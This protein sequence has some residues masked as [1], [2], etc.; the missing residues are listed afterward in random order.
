MDYALAAAILGLSPV[1]ITVITFLVGFLALKM[2]RDIAVNWGWLRRWHGMAIISNILSGITALAGALLAWTSLTVL[3]FF[4]PVVHRF[5]L[6]AA[7]FTLIWM[8]GNAT[9]Q[10]H[11]NRYLPRETSQRLSNE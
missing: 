11:L 4:V 1:L 8:I 5:A 7:F 6:S 9:N 3:G 10:H 2:M